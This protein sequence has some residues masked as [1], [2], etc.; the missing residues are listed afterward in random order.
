MY[1]L[2]PIAVAFGIVAVYLAVKENIWSWPAGIVTAILYFLVFREQ[3]LYANMG[4][5]LFYASI[6]V[7]GWYHWLFGGAQRTRLVVS[8]TPGRERVILPVL[9]VTLALTLGTLLRGYADATLPFVDATLTSGSLCAQYMMSRKYLENWS[10]WIV[11]DVCYVTLFLFRDLYLT[12]F[13]Y[14]VFLVLAVGGRRRW[15]RSLRE[16]MAEPALPES[17]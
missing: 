9:V 7:Y 11:L 2:E 1:P 15:G 13:L 6:A 8:R 4:L 10:L 3:R 12:A 16:A 14:G 17:V 5:Q